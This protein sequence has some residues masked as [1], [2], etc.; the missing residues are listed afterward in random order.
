MI[1]HLSTDLMNDLTV[2]AKGHAQGVREG[3]SPDDPSLL[4]IAIHQVQHQGHQFSL[5]MVY[6]DPHHERQAHLSI[7]RQDPEGGIGP[8]PAT[9]A[10]EI[11]RVLN[12]R[13]Q[14]IPGPG[15]E[16]PDIHHFLLS[17]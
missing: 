7:S 15:H 11:A 2:G 3:M 13:F 12:P 9:A 10:D 5:I 4:I 17:E 8:L 16:A 14:R 1:K 6:D